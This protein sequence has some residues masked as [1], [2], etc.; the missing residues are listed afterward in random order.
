[1]MEVEEYI[2]TRTKRKLN[3]F[4]LSQVKSDN[5]VLEE[6]YEDLFMERF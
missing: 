3:M 1:M 5:K 4:L 6:S 2:R